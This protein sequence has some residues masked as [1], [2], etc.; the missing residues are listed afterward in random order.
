MPASALSSR[1][2]KFYQFYSVPSQMSLLY[3]HPERSAHAR[4]SSATIKF[5]IYHHTESQD[6]S[7]S[8]VNLFI[9]D[10]ISHSGNRSVL[11]P[12]SLQS[13]NSAYCISSVEVQ[14]ITRSACGTSASFCTSTLRSLSPPHKKYPVLSIA[15]PLI[16]PHC[17]R[18]AQHHNSP[19]R[20]VCK[21]ISNFPIAYNHDLHFFSS[22]S[23]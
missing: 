22:I 11:L 21:S 15:V 18:S 17:C 8:I 3:W 10:W 13:D 23:L 6:L 2:R 1:D 16:F 14:A 19:L 12:V 4:I 7:F 5:R 20:A 9:V